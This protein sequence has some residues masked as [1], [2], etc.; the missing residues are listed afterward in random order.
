MI[1]ALPAVPGGIATFAAVGVTGAAIV[2]A[3]SSYIYLRGKQV[4]AAYEELENLGEGVGFSARRYGNR[5]TGLITQWLES[6]KGDDL[7][8]GGYVR[9]HI[10]GSSFSEPMYVKPGS[11]SAGNMPEIERNGETYYFPESAMIPSEEDGIPTVVHRRGE[12]DPINLRDGWSLSVDAKTLTA[13][14]DTAV[15]AN[16][17]A[18]GIGGLLPDSW[19]TMDIMRYGILAIVVGFLALEVLG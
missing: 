11:E 12:S 8:D 17:P 13:Y 18:G 2:G 10:V 15:S 6:G 14:L 4:D 16:A 5:D 1:P 7:L 9:W 19:D 3:L